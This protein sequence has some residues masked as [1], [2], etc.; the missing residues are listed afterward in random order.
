MT[1]ID[2]ISAKFRKIA[3]TTRALKSDKSGLALI[4][5]AYSLPILMGVG[6][7]GAE[8]ANQAVVNMR[9]SQVALHIADNGSRIGESTI[10]SQRRIY[11]SDINDLLLGASIQAGNYIDVFEHGRVIMSS[12]ETNSDGGQWIH[13]QRCKG[14]KQHASTYGNAGDGA[15]GTSFP[16][17]GPTGKEVTAPPGEGVIFV[18]LVYDYQP[19]ISTTFTNTQ[20]IKATATF[21]V[22]D[23]RDYSQ[24][25]QRDTSNPDPVSNCQTFDKF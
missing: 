25:Y 9:I 4:E 14:K 21:N 6:L 17:M 23:S 3:R 22:R 5:F 13:Y 8:T 11:E 15:S 10:L 18:E 24:V 20:T 2:S 7:Y 1:L 12:L 16:G 19:L